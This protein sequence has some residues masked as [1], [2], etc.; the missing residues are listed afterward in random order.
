MPILNVLSIATQIAMALEAAHAAGIVHRDIKP[1]NIMAADSG[2]IKVLDFGVSKVLHAA[3]ENALTAAVTGAT[4]A[5]H[6]VG[7]LAYMSPEQVQGRPIDARSDIFSFG[8]VVY[9][10]LTG[11]RAFVGD[12]SLALVTA[13]LTETPAPIAT[14]RRDVPADLSAL[15][16]ACLTRDRAARPSAH[17]VVQRLDAIQEKLTPRPVAT[18]SLLRRPAVLVPVAI[19]L[20]A[21][22]IAGWMWWRANAKVRW[23]RG[24]AIPE[25]ERLMAR[26]DNDGAFRVAREAIA[27]LPD[28]PYV[29]QLWIDTTF[30]VTFESEPSGA[31]VAVKGYLAHDADWVPLGRTP[32]ESVRVPYAHVRV[33]VTKPGFTPIEASLSSFKVKYTL[34]PEG[35]A[36][37][38]MVRAQAGPA[39]IAGTL[40]AIDDFWIDR[41]EVT[42]Q[43]FKTFVDRGG[44][45][46]PEYWKE[47]FVEN[48]RTLSFAEAIARFRDATG[49]AAPSTWELGTY[50]EGQA[51]LPVTGVSWYEAAAYAA[52]VGKGAADRATT[53]CAR[54]A[55]GAGS[56]RIFRRS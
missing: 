37:A 10:L 55:P 27:L 15:V 1:A 16:Q 32:L 28:D 38:G 4:A 51:N 50:P 18:A 9:E 17:E 6:I 7:T 8:A 39:N 41:L 53:G 30:L 21:V 40:M 5:G 43:D 24:V 3:D 25:I 33:R 12:G 36:P 45:Q 34:D 22:A 56:P 14:L 48:G 13:I 2:Q 35:A 11:R 19:V 26:D 20:L 29:K 47:P 54:P 44:Y 49:K 46:K 23:V 42:N 31:D 52:F